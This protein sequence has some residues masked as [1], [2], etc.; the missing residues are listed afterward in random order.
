MDSPTRSSSAGE[1]GRGLVRRLRDTLF[2]ALQ[3]LLDFISSPTFLR[4]SI[5]TVL[6]FVVSSLLLVISTT[7][8]L[9]FYYA[10]IPPISLSLPL[11]L[12]YSGHASSIAPYAIVDIPSGTLVSQQ[13]YEVTVDLSLPR[14]PTNLDAGVFM[15]DAR[16]LGPFNPIARPPETL[17]ELLGNMTSLGSN[18]YT[19]LRHSRRPTMLK[20]R[21]W[22]LSLARETMLAPLQLIGLRDLDTEV[23]KLRLWEAATFDRTSV[24]MPKAVRVEIATG[25]ANTGSTGLVPFAGSALAPVQRQIQVYSASITFAARF[26]G[27]R[28]V[29]YNYRILSFVTFSTA[30]YIVSIISMGLVWAWIGP[31]ILDSV[32]SEDGAVVKREP[33]DASGIK[34]KTEDDEGSTSVGRKGDHKPGEIS[35]KPGPSTR[36]RLT[37]RS[38]EQI[39]SGQEDQQQQEAGEEQVEAEVSQGETADDE[40]ERPSQPIGNSSS[41]I[42]QRQDRG[43]STGRYGASDSGLG[44]SVSEVSGARARGSR[45]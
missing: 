26:Q 11:Y 2:A 29:I 38:A 9:I 23:V 12:Q 44:L 20:F 43:M 37:Q 34:I 39:S 19:V 45:G 10:Y 30:F 6:F 27:L 35:D 41:S 1:A 22:L 4:I 32:A 24:D 15:V 33:H 18:G 21:S 5:S 31:S 3:P 25:G 17:Q 7:A 28:Y 16:V 36:G 42:Q 14:T 8:Y 13:P 40:D